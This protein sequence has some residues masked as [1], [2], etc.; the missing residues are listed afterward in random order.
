M[1]ARD[2]EPRQIVC[3]C[4]CVYVTACV[5][6]WLPGLA[7]PERLCAEV[8]LIWV[9][10]TEPSLIPWRRLNTHICLNTHTHVRNHTI[11]FH[12]NTRTKH[13]PLNIH[14]ATA[15]SFST[16]PC[17][18]TQTSQYISAI[19]QKCL[20][21]VF[22]PAHTHVHTDTWLDT[23]GP[24]HAWSNTSPRSPPRSNDNTRH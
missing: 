22:F 9:R 21:F 18:T 6:M 12:I 11:S 14:T 15:H 19:S 8:P 4:V 23:L 3:V 5:S 10:D 20:V 17:L 2:I 7:N 13:S 16:H 1:S 24:T